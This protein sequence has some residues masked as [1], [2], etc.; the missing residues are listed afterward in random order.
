MWVIK[1]GG[2]LLGTPELEYW[3]DIVSR[4]GDGKVVI[5]PGGGIFAD[6]VREA[7]QQ[8]GISDKVAHHMAVL[9]MDQYGVL[10]AGLNRK[11]ATAASELE[12]AERGWQH[13]GIVWLPSKMVCADEAIPASWEVT[14]D[15][16][17]AWLATILNA[18]HLILVKS[19]RPI[20]GQGDLHRLIAD[21]VVDPRFGDFVAGQP[22][23]TWVLGKSDYSIFESG[24]S[25]EQLMKTGAAV[26]LIADLEINN[27]RTHRAHL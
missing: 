1:L 23:T 17:A 20:P 15:S 3:L 14:S 2:S 11:L 24:I 16:L 8:S 19:I 6:A 13:R 18:E 26:N 27:E 10:L 9:A 7:Q 21:E 5:V 12:I 25:A 4:Y 22:F